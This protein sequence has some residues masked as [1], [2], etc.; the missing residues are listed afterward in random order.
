[1]FRRLLVPVDFSAC[2][3]QAARHACAMTRMVGGSLILLHVLDGRVTAEQ[4]GGQLALLGNEARHPP[5]LRVVPSVASDVALTILDVAH[6]ERADLL[7]LGT[8]GRNDLGSG[9]LGQVAHRLV[10]AADLPVH[11]VPERLRALAPHA[12]WLVSTPEP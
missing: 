3:L 7:I 8:H 6:S 4:A 2:S 9:V 10:L 12:R 5:Q 11:L 1:M